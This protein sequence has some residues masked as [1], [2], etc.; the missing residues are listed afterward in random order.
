MTKKQ[1]SMMTDTKIGGT[2][3]IGAGDQPYAD[4]TVATDISLPAKPKIKPKRPIRVISSSTAEEPYSFPLKL[5]KSSKLRLY[6][7]GDA[8]DLPDEWNGKFATVKSRN[9]LLALERS[10]FRE[11]YAV[12]KTG[13]KIYVLANAGAAEIPAN[14]KTPK[15]L[16]EYMRSPAYEAA[17]RAVEK[18]H[19][20]S[21]SRQMR[22][23]GFR[24]IHV[25][26][27]KEITFRAS[28]PRIISGRSRVF[29]LSRG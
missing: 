7:A 18:Q 28:K 29:P 5:P 4:A 26:Q 2:L 20:K 13:G 11:P 3:D 19:I 24:D 22:Q 17:E 1:H 15:Q 27:G 9:A 25:S 23:A 14:I 6:W 21:V 10:H 8:K 16:N 12:L